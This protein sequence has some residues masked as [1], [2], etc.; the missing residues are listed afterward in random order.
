MQ[1]IGCRHRA[2]AGIAGAPVGI[3]DLQHH[4][5]V[6]E[7][8]DLPVALRHAVAAAVEMGDALLVELQLVGLAVQFEPA[9]GDSVGAAPGRRAEIGRILRIVIE[10]IEAEDERRL[11][12]REPQILDNRPPG[13]DMRRQ[14]AAGDPHSV[15][16]LTLCRCSKNF[17]LDHFNP[18]ISAG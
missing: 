6:G 15:D 16:G 3:D 13:H 11:V 8:D 4:P 12:A 18:Q 2:V 9:L 10:S 14:S 7:I 1:V 17:A 5:V